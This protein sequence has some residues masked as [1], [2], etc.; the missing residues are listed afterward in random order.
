M[1]KD[2]RGIFSGRAADNLTAALQIR[3]LIEDSGWE[4]AEALQAWF[5]HHVDLWTLFGNAGAELG[6]P[7]QEP[8]R[9]KM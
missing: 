4:E 3:W 6:S 7:G 2:N 8:L 1:S 5:D 9:A